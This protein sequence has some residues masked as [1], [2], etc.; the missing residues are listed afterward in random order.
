MT[1]E[2]DGRVYE[3]GPY[4][5]DTA[6]SSLWRAGELVPLTPKA[7]DTLRT[8]VE[9][10]GRVVSKERLLGA[11][12]PDSFVAENV[13]AVNI[14]TLR[15]ALGTQ[16]GGQFY[17]ENVPKRG[18]RFTADVRV[19]QVAAHTG[20]RRAAT[21]GRDGAAQR[22]APLS[23]AVLPLVNASDDPNVEYL[24]DGITESIINSLAQLAQLR[25]M[26]RSV[27]FRYKGLHVDPQQVGR[28]LD[29]RAVLAGQV[30]QLGER[31][32]IR[33]E[34][35]D[36]ADGRQLW[37]AQYDRNPADLLAVQEEI[38]TEISDRLRLRL[39]T[40][41]RQQLGKR[42]TDDIEAHRLYLRGR[43]FW[44]KRTPDSLQKAIE[45][46]QQASK[47][48][49]HYSLGYSGLADC[50]TLLN[51]YSALRPAVMMPLAHAAAAEALKI[52]PGLAEAHASRAIVEFWYEWD[53][54]GAEASFQQ[55]LALSPGYATAHQ[56]YCWYL[57]ARRRFDEALAAGAR[58][59]ELDP[60]ALPVNMALGKAY[61]FARRYEEALEQC[62]KTLELDA[63]FIP[64]LYFCGRAYEQQGRYDEAIALYEKG[65]IN[66]SG[67]LPL[68]TAILG[69]AYARA[70]EE[71]K[72]RQLLASLHELHAL[73]QRYVPAYGL[74]LI[75][76][77]LGAH[78]E[79][80]AWLDEAC[81]E[82]FLWLVY[83]DVDPAFDALR[84]DPRFAALRLRVGLTD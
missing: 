40:A 75:Y 49:P 71:V 52:D 59:L 43:Y 38:A 69:H 10:S 34:L 42:Y 7:F 47:H 81:A 30:L 79:A 31:L 41:E 14:S 62:Q 23:L 25:V 13:L 5:L 50:Y 11:V 58:A 55:A 67:G 64:A 46:F 4:R 61:F 3:F 39:T 74:G 2:R 82:R 56:W 33:T 72:A 45:Y 48:D 19:R 32:I 36:A 60:L 28:E 57:V 22:S 35:V 63:N 12:W 76:T 26:A 21:V 9:H 68:A 1:S 77:A 51:Y 18:Y 70:G 53:W 73:G 17:I 6:E 65:L 66:L 24:S 54:A 37:G 29:V 78:D 84:A 20:E 15:K 27:V 44:N 80:F 16:A 8:L 83:L